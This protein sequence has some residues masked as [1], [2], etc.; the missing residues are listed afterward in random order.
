MRFS[1]TQRVIACSTHSRHHYWTILTACIAH[2]PIQRCGPHHHPRRWQI[3]GTC[4]AKKRKMTE[5][6]TSSSGA[7]YSP[8]ILRTSQACSE[9]LFASH[10]KRK[11][12]NDLNNT[13]QLLPFR[14]RASRVCTGLERSFLR[15]TELLDAV[16]VLDRASITSRSRV[17]VQGTCRHCIELPCLEHRIA[18]LRVTAGKDICYDTYLFKHR[19]TD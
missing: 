16:S 8:A 3:I 14:A 19:A 2:R 18:K 4:M 9:R 13:I 6:V 10:E 15:T 11:E 1:A 5:T 7:H 12:A 17:V